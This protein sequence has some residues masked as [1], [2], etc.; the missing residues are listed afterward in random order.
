MVAMN[1]KIARNNN[2]GIKKACSKYHEGCHVEQEK[3]IFGQK[4]A[5]KDVEGIGYDVEGCWGRQD[6][7]STPLVVENY[8]LFF[9]F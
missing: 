6:V 4:G 7:R 9:S 8:F 2:K 1:D 5:L 3:N